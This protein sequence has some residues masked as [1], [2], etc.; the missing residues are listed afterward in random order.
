MTAL[1]NMQQIS[2][3]WKLQGRCRLNVLIISAD[4][5]PT[6]F[7]HS[8]TE[9]SLEPA[10]TQHSGMSFYEWILWSENKQKRKG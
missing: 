4:A 5:W 3:Q 8:F 9:S 6:T 1:N 10:M 7:H 2:S